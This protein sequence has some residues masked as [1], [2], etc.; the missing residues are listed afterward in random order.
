M[1]IRA[2]SVRDEGSFRMSCKAGAS[3]ALSSIVSVSTGVLHGP[4]LAQLGWCDH[5]VARLDGI[6][7]DHTNCQR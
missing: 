3:V 5:S 1:Q 6:Q 2:S 7:L 4:W